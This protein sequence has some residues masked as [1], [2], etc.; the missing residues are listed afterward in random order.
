LFEGE[1]ETGAQEQLYIENNGVIAIANELEGV[2]VWAQCSVPT[3]FTRR[4][5]NCL[6]AGRQSARDQSETG[7]AL[8]A[9]KNI[10]R[11]L[12]ATPRCCR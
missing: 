8:A 10:H 4:S 6:R 11:L 9:R 12:P 5:S 1:Y 3:T 2:T 7:A